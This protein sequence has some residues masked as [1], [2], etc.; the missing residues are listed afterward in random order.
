MGRLSAKYI[1]ALIKDI[2]SFTNF[3]KHPPSVQSFYLGGGTPS[4]IGSDLLQT[5][6]KT[7]FESFSVSAPVEVTVEVNPTDVTNDLMQDLCRAGVNR[8]S[9]GIQSLSNKRLLELDRLHTSE[10]AIQAIYAAKA[11]GISSVSIDLLY[12][13]PNQTREGW[14]RDLSKAIDLEPDHISAYSLTLYNASAELRARSLGDIRTDDDLAIYYEMACAELGLA[15]YRHYEVSS[16]AKPGHQSVYNNSIWH[17]SE[18]LGFG[19]GAHATV[20]NRRYSTMSNPASYIQAIANCDNVVDWAEELTQDDLLA[21]S[22][23]GSL[24]TIDGLDLVEAK[25]KFSADL[26]HTHKQLIASLIGSN[27][28]TVEGGRLQLTESGF[29]LADGIAAQLVSPPPP[30]DAL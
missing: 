22:I 5:L 16:W 11:A 20:G 15:Q 18:Y 25:E 6:L 19:C 4:L 14:G 30:S 23:G 7:L 10:Q 1:E 26:T 24:R 8:L 27:Y 12:G 13:L 28:A 29:L 9:I 2:K 21:E 3:L 17:G